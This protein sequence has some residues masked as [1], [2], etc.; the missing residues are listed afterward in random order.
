MKL[1]RPVSQ[2]APLLVDACFDSA[3]EEDQWS[4]RGERRPQQ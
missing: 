4:A 1:C 2:L 3:E